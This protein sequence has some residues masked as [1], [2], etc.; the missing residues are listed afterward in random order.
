MAWV[1]LQEHADIGV[2]R[3]EKDYLRMTALL[4]KVIDKIGGDEDHP[5]AGLAELLGDLIERYED[6]NVR[7]HDADPKAVLEFL[8]KMKG[9]KQTDLA[10]E[11]G[12]QGVVSEILNGKR[13][14]NAR[15]AK[16]LAVRFGVS[17]AVFL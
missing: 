11:I 6:S 8:M 2:I 4:D 15:Q 1:Q 13:A 14:I 5:L 3:N 17:P 7:I 12:S 10:A 16:A 9:L